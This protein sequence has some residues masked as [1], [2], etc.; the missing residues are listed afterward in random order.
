MAGPY[1]EKVKKYCE[2]V[3]DQPACYNGGM[4]ESGL[5]DYKCTCLPGFTGKVEHKVT[6]LCF[7]LL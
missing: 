1:C 6:L 5:D 4:C 3:E 2:I 7:A